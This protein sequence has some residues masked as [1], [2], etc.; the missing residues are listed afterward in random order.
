MA[1][2][3][4]IKSPNYW[5]KTKEI[6]ELAQ[7]RDKIKEQYCV[8]NNITLIIIPY[9]EENKLKLFIADYFIL[10]DEIPL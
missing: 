10:N 8:E 2:K 3:P 1:K 5:H 9:T 4:T 7:Q 6:F